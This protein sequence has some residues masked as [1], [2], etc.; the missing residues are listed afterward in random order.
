MSLFLVFVKYRTKL[1]F[2]FRSR[3]TVAYFF[4]KLLL[5]FLFTINLYNMTLTK[6]RFNLFRVCLS[7]L[8]NLNGA[9]QK[10]GK[11]NVSCVMKNSSNCDSVA[12]SR[13]KKNFFQVTKPPR[14]NAFIRTRENVGALSPCDLSRK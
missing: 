9:E 7:N 13:A 3:E 10:K 12:N 2:F 11:K 6:Q 5:L 14:P 4:F 8:S 1:V